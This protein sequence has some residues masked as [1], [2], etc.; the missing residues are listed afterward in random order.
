MHAQ[1]S[2]LTFY[3]SHVFFIFINFDILFISTYYYL[4]IWMN[5]NFIDFLYDFYT[6]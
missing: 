3:F 2:R 1:K 5:D 6:V 4:I